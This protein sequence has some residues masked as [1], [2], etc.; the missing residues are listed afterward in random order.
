MLPT[1]SASLMDPD[2][3]GQALGPAGPCGILQKPR[4]Q[5][6]FPATGPVASRAPVSRRSSDCQRTP[7]ST[8]Q[9]QHPAPALLWAKANTMIN[10]L[11]HGAVFWA[12]QQ[13]RVT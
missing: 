11:F 4:S 1:P 10:K 9:F 5:A 7:N 13:L 3:Q 8:I 6:G 12:F 2:G